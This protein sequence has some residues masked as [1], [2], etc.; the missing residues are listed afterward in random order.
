MPKD[1]DV[2]PALDSDARDQLIRENAM[3]K[4]L[5]AASLGKIIE[6]EKIGRVFHDF[7]NILSSSMGYANLALERAKSSDDEKLV[8]YLDNI[9]RAGIRARDLVRDS[10]DSRRVSRDSTQTGPAAVLKEG[11]PGIHVDLPESEA[12]FYSAEQLALLFSILLSSYSH[13]SARCNGKV[14]EEFSC[15]GCGED[16][17]GIQLKVCMDGLAMIDPGVDRESFTLAEA[18]IKSQAGHICE[19][20]M[21]DKQFVVYLRSVT[22]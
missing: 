2:K 9:E 1:Q 22:S 11:F 16:L 19:S 20:L 10:L 7:N 17:R 5:L 21:Q 12:V 6:D 4:T 14:V 15:E 18:L 13:V 3:L 8:R